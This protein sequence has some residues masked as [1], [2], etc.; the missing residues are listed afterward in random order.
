MRHPSDGALRR[1]LDEPSGVAETDRQHAADC[2]RCRSSVDAMQAD[3][4][5]VAALMTEEST[6]VDVDGAWLVASTSSSA[7]ARSTISTPAAARRR[8]L[9]RPVAAALAFVVVL[10]GAGVAAAN[11]WLPIF[12]TERVAPVSI[13]AADLLALPDLSAYGDLLVTSRPNVR[14]VP[15]AAA[16]AAATGLDV[17]QV[18]DLPRGVRG[19]PVVQVGSKASV[20]FTFST[21]RAAKAA[22]AAGKPLPPP[23][24][25]LDGSSVRLD[26]GPG[27]AQVWSSSAG[28]PALIVGRAVAPTA[29]SSGVRFETMRDYLLSLPGLP[30]RVADQLRAFAADDSTL[31]LPVPADRVTTRSARVRGVDAVVLTTRDRTMAGVVWVADAV[32]TVVAGSLDADEVLTVARELT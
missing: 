2:P 23:P 10:T 13:T 28:V 31:P 4:A 27:V 29:Y 25:G 16:A 14:A 15:D 30:E 20:T 6:E 12:R 19:E 7:T 17:P 26:A 32:V 8:A 3:A 18:T 22:A 24:L 1:L 11:D 5:L 9:A 21:E